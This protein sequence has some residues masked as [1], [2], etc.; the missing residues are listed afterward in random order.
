[1]VLAKAAV[2]CLRPLSG[3]V[4]LGPQQAAQEAVRLLKERG[5]GAGGLILLDRHGRPGFA[6][7]TPHMAYGYVAADGSF[8]VAV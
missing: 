7:N 2:D 5:K 3:G 6:F 8:L 1:V 4:P